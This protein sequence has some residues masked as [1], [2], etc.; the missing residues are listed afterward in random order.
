MSDGSSPK[1]VN[2]RKFGNTDDGIVQGF[3]FLWLTSVPTTFP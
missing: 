2:L 1:A 3:F